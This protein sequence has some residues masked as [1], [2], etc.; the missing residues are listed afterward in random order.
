MRNWR[1]RLDRWARNWDRLPEATRDSFA[2]RKPSTLGW[3]PELPQC[4][5][6]T[7]F[8]TRCDGGTFGRY[9]LSAKA[10]LADPSNGWLAD[11]PGLDLK[12]GR[13]IE[14]GN[15]EYGHQLLWDADADEV[16]LYS[17]D[18]EEPRRFKRSME[19]FLQGLFSPPADAE[20]ETIRMW[21]AALAESD[22]LG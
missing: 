8:Y 15:H 20:N 18:D 22:E 3:P 13:W 11:S 10:D 7:E 16:M 9:D 14:F 2:I 17:S 5:P 19:R 6:L 1:E 21:F 4:A 12:P